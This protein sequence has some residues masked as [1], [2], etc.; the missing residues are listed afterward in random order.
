MSWMVGKN[1]YTFPAGRLDLGKKPNINIRTEKIYNNYG[2][3]FSGMPYGGIYGGMYGGFDY[4]YGYGSYDNELS[5]GEKWM[6][7]LGGIASLGGAILSAFTGKKVDNTQ[8]T[9]DTGTAGNT[10]DNSQLAE[11]EQQNQ[12]LNANYEKVVEENKKLS[13]L[14]KLYQEGITY[15]E[16][17]DTYSAN[18]TDIFGQKETITASTVEE[19][20]E[21]KQ[22]KET[23]VEE[24]KKFCADN[25]IEIKSDGTFATTIKGPDGQEQIITGSTPEAVKQEAEDK[26]KILNSGNEDLLA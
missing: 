15:N 8:E 5:K 12:E 1:H 23:E 7:A 10:S 24:Q 6:L 13:E 25:N 21:A 19:I 26:S 3:G 17:D 22:K 20:K 2:T 11:L 18:V 14:S 16:T 4:G 9:A